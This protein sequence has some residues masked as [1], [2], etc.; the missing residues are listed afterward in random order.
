MT[1][2]AI[3]SAALERELALIAICDHNAVGNV[4]ATQEVAGDALAVVAGME[5]TTAEE[6]HVLGLFPDVAVARTVAD[7][8]QRTL[9]EATPEDYARFGP[10]WVMDA[11][12]NVIAIEDRLLAAASAFS[13]EAVVALVHGCGG[14]AVAAH[15][16]R[17][18]MSVLSQLGMIPLGIGL[19]A[20]EVWE[21]AQAGAPLVDL[22]QYGLPLVR[23]SDSHYLGDVGCR[24]TWLEC[25]RPNFGELAQALRNANGRRVVDA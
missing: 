10:Q 21:S 11:A 13:L 15:A 14:L 2:R 7:E 8:V 23:S 9:P 1:P 4:A 12:G 5:V 16:N 20:L 3:V 22:A 24:R 18:S 6:V 25:A 19:D 17:P